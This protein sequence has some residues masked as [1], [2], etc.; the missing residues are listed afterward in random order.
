MAK[1]REEDLNLLTYFNNEERE[2][3]KCPHCGEILTHLEVTRDV[4]RYEK[5]ALNGECIDYEDLEGSDII[6]ECGN[7]HH[8]LTDNH[9]NQLI[10]CDLLII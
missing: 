3:L 2:L 6:V 1:Y 7:C 5:Y 4:R 10:D 8:E 9:V